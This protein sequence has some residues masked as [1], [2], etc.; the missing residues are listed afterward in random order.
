MRFFISGIVI[1]SWALYKKIS[2]VPKKNEFKTL[3]QLGILFTTQLLLLNIGISKTSVSSSIILNSTYPIWVITLSHFF[4]REDKI[5]ILKFFGVIIA[6]SGIVVTYFDSIGNS[7]YLIGNTLCLISGFLLGVR[8]VFLAKNSESIS[9][10]KL[11]MSQAIFGTIFF[12]FLSTIFES[13][14]YRMSI[15]LILS[16]LYQGA[17]IAGFNFIANMWLLK[18][19]TP[20]EVIVIRLS[21]PIFGILIGWIVLKEEIGLLVLLGAFLVILGSLIVRKKTLLKT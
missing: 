19:Y 16:I 14:P 18:N 12:L 13:D 4:I 17:V 9:S 7:S 8:T 21:E 10:L 2:L 1:F 20:S 15:I 5:T 3:I 6:Y 11:L